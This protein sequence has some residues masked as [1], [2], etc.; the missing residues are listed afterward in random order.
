MK[1]QRGHASV[2]KAKATATA[3]GGD[4]PRRFIQ[5]AW[6]DMQRKSNKIYPNGE[7]FREDYLVKK[8]HGHAQKVVVHLH[9]CKSS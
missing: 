3:K 8:S 1:K 6:I 7:K 5:G 2:S 4:G 9:F